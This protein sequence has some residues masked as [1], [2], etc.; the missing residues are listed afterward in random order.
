MT[1]SQICTLHRHLD[2]VPAGIRDYS[3]LARF[4]YRGDCLGPVRR[5]FKLIDRHRRR[6][7]AAPVVGIIVYASP[8]ANLAARNRATGGLFSGLDRSA[9]LTV[10]NERLC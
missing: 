2:I 6:S 5:M 8:P 7:L 9:A 3:E 4:H 10:L 1:H